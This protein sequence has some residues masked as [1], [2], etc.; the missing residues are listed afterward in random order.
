MNFIYIIANNMDA[1][2]NNGDNNLKFLSLDA[3]QNLKFYIYEWR[4]VFAQVNTAIFSLMDGADLFATNSAKNINPDKNIIRAKIDL[5]NYTALYAKHFIVRFKNPHLIYLHSI[6]GNDFCKNDKY[7]SREIKERFI[8]DNNFYDVPRDYIYVNFNLP[9]MYSVINHINFRINIENGLAADIFKDYTYSRNFWPPVPTIY[10]ERFLRNPEII[11]LINQRYTKQNLVKY[12]YQ[13]R[14]IICFLNYVIFADPCD[15]FK[16]IRLEFKNIIFDTLPEYIARFENYID[17]YNIIKTGPLQEV[18]ILMLKK[19]HVNNDYIPNNSPRNTTLALAFMGNY[20][21]FR[22]YYE[23][24]DKL[25]APSLR[26]YR[27][28]LQK[29]L[30]KI[31]VF[32]IVTIGDRNFARRAELYNHHLIA[33]IIAKYNIEFVPQ[34][35]EH[36][37][38]D[39]MAIHYMF[40]KLLPV[41]NKIKST[42]I[43]T[44]NEIISLCERKN[45]KII[46]APLPLLAFASDMFIYTLSKSYNSYFIKSKPNFLK[47]KLIKKLL[48][49]IIRC[50]ICHKSNKKRF[51]SSLNPK[52][53]KITDIDPVWLDMRIFP[54]DYI[55]LALEHSNYFALSMLWDNSFITHYFNLPDERIW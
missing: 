36:I 5:C 15:R 8:A 16:H 49:L 45:D 23:N 41:N 17:A 13:N 6:K 52:K 24:N 22:M 27:I 43:L 37:D 47:G 29:K 33:D 55:E 9:K 53:L 26:F 38:W 32:T 42:D 51:Y 14:S 19:Y 21:L 40:E 11:K 54:G 10:I 39:V 3:I 34:N 50:M 2:T 35:E 25:I 20:D 18:D 44:V 46:Y 4:Y 1:P 28:C 12:L 7:I 48:R 31:L 30:K